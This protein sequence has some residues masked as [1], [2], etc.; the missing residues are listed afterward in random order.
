MP[1]FWHIQGGVDWELRERF[2][3]H[4]HLNYN[5]G[6]WVAGEIQLLLAA[7]RSRALDVETSIRFRPF[8]FA[9][10]LHGH[11]PEVEH[12][13][14]LPEAEQADQLLNEFGVVFVLG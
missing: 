9:L 2:M 11:G 8:A 4:I 1:Y 3:V 5:I 13:D 10:R 14:A 7:N 6:R 12:F